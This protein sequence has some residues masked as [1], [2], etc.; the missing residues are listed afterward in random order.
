MV[1]CLMYV[2][3]AEIIVCV[4]VCMCVCD[5]QCAGLSVLRS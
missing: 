3:C 5:V 2:Q 4:C 1:M